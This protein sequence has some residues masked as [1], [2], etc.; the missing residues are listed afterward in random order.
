MT[1]APGP[2]TQQ[3]PEQISYATPV[4]QSE[5]ESEKGKL[6]SLIVFFQC[7]AAVGIFFFAGAS[8]P[9]VAA[10]AILAAVVIAMAHFI[11]SRPI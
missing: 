10:L 9:A 11:T 6:L 7:A 1:P 8:W 3:R 4:L 2:D 5:K